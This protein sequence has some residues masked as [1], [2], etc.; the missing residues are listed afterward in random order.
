MQLGEGF[1]D[2]LGFYRRTGVRKWFT[3]AGLR[4]GPG[5]SVVSAGGRC[6]PT[7]P[8]P[9]TRIWTAG[10]W[11]R[12]STPPPA[13][14]SKAVPGSKLSANP[15]FERIED[16]FTIDRRVDPI[17]AGGYHWNEWMLRGSTDASRE[18]LLPGHRASLAG[19]GAAPR[20]PFEA[21]LT[22]K[23]TYKFEASLG[24]QR[25]AAELDL[26]Q[27]E[28]VKTFW[29]GEDLLLLHP[30]M[31]LDALVQYDPATKQYNSNVR[32]NFIHHPLSDLY[33][34]WNEQR[35]FT[36]EEVTPGRSLTLKVDPDGVVLGVWPSIRPASDPTPASH[37]RRPDLAP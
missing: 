31:F 24:L 18:Y 20:R 8:G 30:D 13:S 34:V 4:P 16:P 21:T 14:S 25:T 5:G 23:P 15:I 19:F 33:I 3:D 26:P 17:P 32:F 35:F 1:R 6:T 10:W 2:D 27:A 29:T 7:S 12:S 28:F 37:P 22:A 9:T 11:P 36:G